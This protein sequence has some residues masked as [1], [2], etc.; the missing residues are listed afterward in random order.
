MLALD[1]GV[2]SG[3]FAGVVEFLPA[4]ETARPKIVDKQVVDDAHEVASLPISQRSASQAA[5]RG[6][7]PTM[8]A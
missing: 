1:L 2:G 8:S 7:G 4:E 3:G 5:V 6:T